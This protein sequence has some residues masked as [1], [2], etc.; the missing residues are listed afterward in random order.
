[1]EKPARHPHTYTLMLLTLALEHLPPSFPLKRVAHYASIRDRCTGDAGCTYEDIRRAIVDLGKESWPE[2]MAYRD[3]YERYGTASEEA[4]LLEALDA[5]IREK[6]ERFVHEG[7]KIDYIRSAKGAVFEA[8][9][10]ERYFS[11]EEVFGIEQ[12]LLAARE[13]AHDE[14]DG[15]VTGPKKEEYGQLVGEYKE[16]MVVIEQGIA[17]MR[18]LA[19]VSARLRPEIMDRVRTLEEGWSVVERGTDAVGVEKELEHWQGML[20][21]FLHA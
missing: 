11:P 9:P 2:R 20:E 19:D 6:Y 17:E 5:G 15:L 1:M 10:F 16:E 13:A 8:T 12:A 4:N 3:M 7:G 21:A 18:K 14:I